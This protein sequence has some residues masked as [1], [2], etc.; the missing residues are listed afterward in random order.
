MTYC[1]LWKVLLPAEKWI[2]GGNFISEQKLDIQVKTEYSV[3]NLISE[4]KLDIRTKTGCS[5]KSWIF[6][7]KLDIRAKAGCLSKNW[8]FG[9]NFISEQKLDIPVASNVAKLAPFLRL[10]N[11]C[12]RV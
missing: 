1:T 12:Q 7:Q 3:E 11:L 8:I 6:G 4:L 10:A 2:F 9:Q 5:S